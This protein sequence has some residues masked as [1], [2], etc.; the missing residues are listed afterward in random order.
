MMLDYGIITNSELSS[1]TK[2]IQ[3]KSNKY[4]YSKYLVLKL[5]LIMEKTTKDKAD[6]VVKDMYLY[7]SSQ[8][9]FSAPY[10]KLE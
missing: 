5:L 8:A 2:E 4:R 7:A 10:V 9:S 3:K 1:T 6:E